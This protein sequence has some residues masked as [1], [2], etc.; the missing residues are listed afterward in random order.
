MAKARKTPSNNTRTI[1][2]NPESWTAHEVVYI[3]RE[4]AEEIRANARLRNDRLC[5]FDEEKAKHSR[6]REILLR[7]LWEFMGP[8]GVNLTGEDPY[9]DCPWYA[10]PGRN[11]F[12]TGYA[13]GFFMAGQ[14]DEKLR[15]VANKRAAQASKA[16]DANAAMR[17]D[18]EALRL[19]WER[20]EGTPTTH[21]L[22]QQIKGLKQDTR[23]GWR[24]AENKV[25]K[26]KT[27][28]TF[29]SGKRR[30]WGAIRRWVEG[31]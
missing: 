18:K 20:L 17:Q 8:Q 15:E 3:T 16:R 21:R 29:P 2:H 1:P 25:E 26:D 13:V 23:S 12:W 4:E 28:I 27:T 14:H 30:C 5:F 10:L 31:F 6:E 11:A 24:M 9:P 7:V 22:F 19:L